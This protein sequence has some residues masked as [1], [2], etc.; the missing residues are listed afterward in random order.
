MIQTVLLLQ[1]SQDVSGLSESLF[2]A[3]AS[4]SQQLDIE[5]QKSDFVD[6]HR[7]VFAFSESVSR[8]RPDVVFLLVA[9]D[10]TKDASVLI[11][12]I[13]QQQ[14]NLPLIVVIEACEPVE[15]FALLELVQPESVYWFHPAP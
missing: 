10:S 4:S 1:D 8:V 3:L 13:K 12:L 15:M 6:T 11:P 9:K 5:Q 2:E 14:P 7:S